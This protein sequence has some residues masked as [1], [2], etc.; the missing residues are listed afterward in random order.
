MTHAGMTRK[1]NATSDSG[2]WAISKRPPVTDNAAQP[3]AK[4]GA[5]WDLSR[6][7]ASLRTA[8][9]A[10]SSAASAGLDEDVSQTPAPAPGVTPPS[11]PP[12]TTAPAGATKKAKLKSGPTY[13]P[14]GTIKATKSGGQKTA[15]FDLSVEFENDTAHGID[16]ASG[17]VHQYM[18]WT[19]ADET[20]NHAGFRPK[21]G[22]SA[23]TWYEDR[24]SVGKRYGHRTGSY[25]EC[26]SSNHYT[27]K[28]GTENCASGAVFAGLDTPTDGS[29]AKT[30][31]WKFE[32]RAYDTANGNGLGTPAAVTVDWNV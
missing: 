25:A 2:R 1:A 3:G 8:D 20:P 10:K 31:L 16:P 26:A 14:S 21:S 17:E 11:P 24:D 29:G 18:M 12:P 13:T 27:D 9:T 30:G 6:V 22:F 15:S 19:K 32:L 4:R 23:N 7:P 5:R 28:D